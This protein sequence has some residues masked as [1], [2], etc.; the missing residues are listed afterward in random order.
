V[1][2]GHTD[3]L[4]FKLTNSFNEERN[5]YLNLD[6]DKKDYKSIYLQIVESCDRCRGRCDR[7]HIEEQFICNLVDDF[8]WQT[9]C[10][11]VAKT[12]WGQCLN[13]CP[14]CYVS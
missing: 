11:E 1:L 9:R 5:N 4:D 3:F 6:L 13:G 2:P 14:Q 8:G 12:R 7:T 10:L